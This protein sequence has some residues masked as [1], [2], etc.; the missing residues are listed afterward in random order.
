MNRKIIILSV[1]YFIFSKKTP[2]L[3]VLEGFSLA[4]SFPSS[5]ADHDINPLMEVGK[6][7]DYGVLLYYK[8]AAIPDL[9]KLYDFYHSNCTSLSLLGRVRLSSNG[10]NV[11]VIPRFSFVSTIC[12]RFRRKILCIRCSIFLWILY[13]FFNLQVGGR[14]KALEEHIEAVKS[15]PLFEGT[16]FKLASCLEPLNDQVAKECGFTSLCVRMVKVV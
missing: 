10:V 9:Q 12:C 8:Y 11:T 3:R 4:E 7:K 5:M 14:L 13:I 1:Y 16:D 2:N 15:N 6:E